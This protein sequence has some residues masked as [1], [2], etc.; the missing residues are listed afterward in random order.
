M[1]EKLRW[2]GGGVLREKVVRNNIFLFFILAFQH[3]IN[4]LS[5]L[6]KNLRVLFLHYC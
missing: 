6:G 2:V 1:W 4:V 3:L 5:I